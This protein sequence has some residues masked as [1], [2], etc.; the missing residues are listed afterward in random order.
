MT[1]AH[2]AK[3]LISAWRKDNQS[4]E[5]KR[6]EPG[7]QTLKVISKALMEEGVQGMLQHAMKEGFDPDH[8]SLVNREAERRA[9]IWLWDPEDTGKMSHECVLLAFPVVGDLK[10]LGSWI[11][12]P[13]NQE[14]LEAL[15][16]Q[17][18]ELLTALSREDIEAVAV[19]PT[20]LHPALVANLTAEVRRKGMMEILGHGQRKVLPHLESQKLDLDGI[21]GNKILGEAVVLVAAVTRTDWGAHQ[22]AAMHGVVEPHR[23][24][25]LALGHM[26]E[27]FM[28]QAQE[29]WN[30]SVQSLPSE[31]PAALQQPTSVNNALLATLHSGLVHIRQYVLY[32]TDPADAI[33]EW[34]GDEA[35]DHETPIHQLSVAEGEPG[36]IMLDIK[37]M[38]AQTIVQLPTAWAFVE[39]EEAFQNLLVQA[40][41][42]DDHDWQPQDQEN[43]D[44]PASDPRDAQGDHPAWKRAMPTPSSMH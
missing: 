9:G 7:D 37:T 10:A 38:H 4:L 36:H 43:P 3:T 24:D 19:L 16:H 40:M 18:L 1:A 35:E 44:P 26:D 41:G 33:E 12:T 17:H 21:D 22:P 11:S 8:A 25:E 27:D 2:L 29:I 5:H 31:G 39:G 30:K 42:L 32:P 13:E 14:V 34:E 28:S 6:Q 20:L 15:A 23:V